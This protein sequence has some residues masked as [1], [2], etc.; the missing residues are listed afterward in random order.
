MKEESSPR[1]AKNRRHINHIQVCYTC[2]YELKWD[3]IIMLLAM[4]FN[5]NLKYNDNKKLKNLSAFFCQSK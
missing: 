2:C 1:G 4:S 3:T 5:D